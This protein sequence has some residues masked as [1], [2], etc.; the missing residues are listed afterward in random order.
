MHLPEQEELLAERSFFK[1][2]SCQVTPEM[3]GK[4]SEKICLVEIIGESKIPYSLEQEC[5]SA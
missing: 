3:K 4:W 5:L 2:D 1:S